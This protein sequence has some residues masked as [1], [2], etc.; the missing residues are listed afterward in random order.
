MGKSARRWF[1]AFGNFLGKGIEDV[2]SELLRG[3]SRVAL[4]VYL[5]VC[6]RQDSQRCRCWIL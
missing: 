2:W 6:V 1:R 5:V 4:S 3:Y